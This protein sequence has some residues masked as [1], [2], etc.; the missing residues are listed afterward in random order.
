[1][2]KGV[3]FIVISVI[4]IDKLHRENVITSIFK[5]TEPFR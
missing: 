1:M 4:F 3:F 2:D 5:I